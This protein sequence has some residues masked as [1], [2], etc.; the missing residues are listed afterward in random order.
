L[1]LTGGKSYVTAGCLSSQREPSEQ[2]YGPDEILLG[3]T[4]ETCRA[5]KKHFEQP[6]F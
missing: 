4:D 3:V 1:E 6:C 5:D 2:Y